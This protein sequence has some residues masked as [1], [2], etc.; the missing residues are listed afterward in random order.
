MNW[1]KNNPLAIV[2]VVCILI[3]L[4]GLYIVTS[5]S[6][7][8]PGSTGTWG[9]TGAYFSSTQGSV[10]PPMKPSN[11]I[12]LPESSPVDDDALVIPRAGQSSTITALT[13]EAASDFGSLLAE[14]AKGVS[15]ASGTTSRPEI[16]TA[17]DFLPTVTVETGA[18]ANAT[19]EQQALY[20]YGN[21]IGSYIKP[22]RSGSAETVSILN[23][24]AKDRADAAKGEAVQAIAQRFIDMGERIAGIKSVPES[25][26][27]A[28]DALAKGYRAVGENLANIPSASTDQEFLG[29]ITKYNTAADSFT[30]A[31]INIATIF[32]LNN[33][34]FEESD[35]GSVFTF[36]GK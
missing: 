13:E 8:A 10:L 17:F 30:T 4:A 14:I 32:S 15:A 21:L 7:V 6:P 3:V 29:A 33:V 11:T 26:R 31:F 16:I 22:F 5:R 9:T 25:V 23:A 2:L 34:H 12:P 1:L 36:N 20:A 24:Q 27:T 35:P 18:R 19:P 28:H